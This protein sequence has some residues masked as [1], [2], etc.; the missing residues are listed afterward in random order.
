[1]FC[2]RFPLTVQVNSPL[3]IT[4]LLGTIWIAPSSLKGVNGY[5]IFTTRDLAAGESLLGAPDGV[6]VPVER[7]QHPSKPAVRE[8]SQFLNLFGEYMWGRGVPDHVTYE[9]PPDILDFQ[10]GFGC[11]PNHHCVLSFLDMVY[12]S[13]PYDDSLVDRFRDPSAGAFSYNRGREFVVDHSVAAGDEIFLNYGYCERSERSPAWTKSMHMTQDF[14]QAASLILRHFKSRRSVL[15]D[16]MGVLVVPPRMSNLVAS[17]LPRTVD[18]LRLQ[19]TNITFLST[20]EVALQVARNSL[21]R[22]SPE[23]IREHGIC[24]D[25]LLAKPSTLPLAGQGAFAQRTLR[26]GDMIT[27]APLMQIVNKKSLHIYNKQGQRNGTQ[28]LLNYCFGHRQSTMLLCPNT[29][30]V[31]IN[32]CSL[33]TK[34]CGPLGPNAEY[35]W[36]SGWDP[37]S[38]AWRY[39]PVDEI[40]EQPVRGLAFE[41]VA[42]RDIYPGDEVFIDYGIE[43]EQAWTQHVANWRPPPPPPTKWIPAKEANEDTGPVRPEFVSGDLRKTVNHPYL[44]TGCLYYATKWDGHSVF[45]RSNLDWKSMSD[46]ELLETF[47][48]SGE[49]YVYRDQHMYLHHVDRSHWPCTVLRQEEDGSYIVRIHRAPW[50]SDERLPWHENGLPRLLH[51]YRRESIHYFVHPFAS[52]QH[53]P[54]VFRHEIRIRDEIF[55]RQWKNIPPDRSHVAYPSELPYF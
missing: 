33:R 47:S 21:H 28:L 54:G 34:E 36:S 41:I 26:Q 46:R 22:R 35:R 2:G 27:P 19:Y 18:E 48:D 55:P 38:D 29:N 5:G 15:F 14:Q 20:K 23:W 30:A 37:T 9:A 31:L 17:L 3:R 24:M 49:S 6:A 50:A 4:T 25:N 51:N 10:I 44:F 13:P 52:D 12:P 1:V 16:D 8:R 39:L 42:T 45:Q 32:H 43:W 40:T 7:Y 53:L 11:L